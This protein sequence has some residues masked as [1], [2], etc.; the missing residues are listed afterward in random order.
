ML[1]VVVHD[2]G[3]EQGWTLSWDSGGWRLSHARPA[4]PIARIAMPAETFWRLATGGIGS[5]EARQT[6]II[7]GDPGLAEPAFGIVAVV[8]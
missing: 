3:R 4:T 7:Q 1:L 8:R 2:D 6:T 5:T